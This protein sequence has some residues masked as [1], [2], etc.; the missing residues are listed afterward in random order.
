[1]LGQG[2]MAMPYGKTLNERIRR[3]SITQSLLFR[4]HSTSHSCRYSFTEGTM[5]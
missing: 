3:D 1:M 2:H 5:H 4:T